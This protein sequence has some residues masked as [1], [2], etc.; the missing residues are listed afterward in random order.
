M[1]R[2]GF[3]FFSVVVM[4][5]LTGCVITNATMLG[6]AKRRVRLRKIFLTSS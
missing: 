6:T 1:K 3:W 4:L 2:R 5:R